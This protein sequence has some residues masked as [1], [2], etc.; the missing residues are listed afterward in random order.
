MKT[1]YEKFGVRTARFR[2][3]SFDDANYADLV[4][5]LQLPVMFK[6]VDSSGSRGIIRILAIQRDGP[7]VVASDDL[8]LV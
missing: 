5:Q 3:I 6:S 2:R 7:D 8:C 4:A 1:C